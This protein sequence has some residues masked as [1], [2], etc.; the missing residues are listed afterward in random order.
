MA[1][2]LK[3]LQSDLPVGEIDVRV[4][5]VIAEAMKW[6]G[7]VEEAGNRGAAIERFQKAVDGI[8]AGEPYCMGWVQFLFKE[9]GLRSDI[10][11]SEHCMTV[12]RNSPKCLRLMNPKRGCIPIWRFGESDSGHAGIVS[13]VNGALMKTI[14]ANTGPAKGVEREGDGVYEKIRLIR[15]TEGRMKIVG[16]LWPWR[17]K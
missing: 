12:W 4:E 11:S 9:T 8:A 14:E 5:A 3:P 13:S 1:S 17:E 10:F 16:F 15:P 6:V 2:N 7:T